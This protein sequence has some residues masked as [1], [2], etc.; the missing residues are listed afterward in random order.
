MEFY[1][2]LIGQFHY[3]I[4]EKIVHH[5]IVGDTNDHQTTSDTNSPEGDSLSLTENEEKEDKEAFNYQAQLRGLPYDSCLQ[6][7]DL[8]MVAGSIFSVAPGEGHKPIGIHTD[9]HFEEMCNPTK[10]PRGK[11]WL[12]VKQKGKAYCSQ[13]L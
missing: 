6:R 12:D 7:E 2:G 5:P 3:Q 8:E 11:V 13:V 10:Y 1:L 9:E 4:L